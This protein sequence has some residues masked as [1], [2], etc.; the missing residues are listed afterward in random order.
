MAATLQLSDTLFRR[1]IASMNQPVM[2]TYGQPGKDCRKL[3]AH[4]VRDTP[5]SPIVT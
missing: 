4:R 3:D 1:L 5:P 2:T